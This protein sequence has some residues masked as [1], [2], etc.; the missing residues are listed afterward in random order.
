MEKNRQI[1]N[2]HTHI[3]TSDHV[4]PFLGKSLMPWPIYFIVNIKWLI[5]IVRSWKKKGWLHNIYYFIKHH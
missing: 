5:T 2:C 1:V 3:F 4:P